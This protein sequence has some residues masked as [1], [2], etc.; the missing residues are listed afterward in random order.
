[1]KKLIF[2]LVLLNLLLTIPL[3][4]FA[5]ISKQDRVNDKAGSDVLEKY[6]NILNSC[7]MNGTDID[8]CLSKFKAQSSGQKSAKKQMTFGNYCCVNVSGGWGEYAYIHGNAYC[9][10]PC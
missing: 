2:K 5:A 10:P 1:M 6:T 7:K 3:V 8:S 4:S 9:I